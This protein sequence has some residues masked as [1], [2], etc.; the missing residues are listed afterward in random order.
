MQQACIYQAVLALCKKRE[1]AD[2]GGGWGGAVGRWG[3]QFGFT[4]DCAVR[5]RPVTLL[6][7]AMALCV[8]GCS[9]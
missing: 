7:Q 5:L 1:L 8:V 2:P 3:M 9:I 4:Q 6:P